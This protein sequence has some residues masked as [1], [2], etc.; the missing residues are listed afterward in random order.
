ME[1]LL[2]TAEPFKQLSPGE[3]ARLAQVAREKHYAKGEPI[4]RA[5][6]PSDAVWIVKTG[7]V[8]LMKFLADGKTAFSVDRY[9]EE[10]CPTPTVE[11]PFH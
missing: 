3:R 5:G 8:H 6:E 4:F 9:V 11:V 2:A 7:R 10:Y 1:R